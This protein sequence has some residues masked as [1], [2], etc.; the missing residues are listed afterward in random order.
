MAGDSLAD[1]DGDVGHRPQHGGVRECG[2]EIGDRRR[3][4]HGDDRAGVLQLGGDLRQRLRLDCEQD[5][6]GV[7][8]ELAERGAGLASDLGGQRCGAAG[9]RVGEQHQLGTALGSGESA[10]QRGGHVPRAR[11]SDLHR[12]EP[13]WSTPRDRAREGV[14]AVGRRP[15][16]TG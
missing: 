13:R 14:D 4:E 15:V 16:R 8:R 6:V 10:R 7:A 11:E 9:A 3:A 1:L 2:L 12:R 5:Q